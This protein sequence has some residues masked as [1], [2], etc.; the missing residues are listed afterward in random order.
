MSEY[1][2]VC[3][4]W[5]FKQESNHVGK[6]MGWGCGRLFFKYCGLEP[7]KKNNQKSLSMPTP[8]FSKV[9]GG[10]AFKSTACWGR[11]EDCVNHFIS[12]SII[13]STQ[14]FSDTS[15]LCL[16]LSQQE[17]YVPYCQKKFHFHPS[18]MSDYCNVKPLDLNNTSGFHYEKKGLQFGEFLLPRSPGTN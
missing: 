15:W 4:L 7:L 1:S 3:K 10:G 18:L 2:H 12:C 13:Y 5:K 9:W 6:E 11:G 14:V 8:S 17:N 16:I